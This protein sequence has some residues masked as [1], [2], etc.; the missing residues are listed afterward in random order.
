MPIYEYR[1]NDC[2]KTFEAR[3][4]FS[5]DPLTACGQSSVECPASVESKGKGAVSRLLSSPA[6]QFKGSGWYITDYAKGNG[7]S[8]SNKNSGSDSSSDTKTE[9]KTESKPAAASTES[10]SSSAKKD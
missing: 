9:T 6:F 7:N 10:S 1:C 2:G 8:T 4:K 3:Q 5:D